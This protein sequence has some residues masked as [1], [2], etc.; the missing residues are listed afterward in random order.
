M[1]QQSTVLNF[2]YIKM[3]FFLI[4]SLL[5]CSALAQAGIVSYK[6]K[7]YKKPEKQHELIVEVNKE[8]D[9]MSFTLS[10]NKEF[11]YFKQD[12]SIPLNS[13]NHLMASATVGYIGPWFQYPIQ[14]E[15]I[16]ISK[17]QAEDYQIVHDKMNL[18]NWELTN[19]TKIIDGYECYKATRSQLNDRTLEFYTLVAWYTPDVSV[20]YGPIGE[21]YLPGLILQLIVADSYEYTV[22]EMTL[23]P[24]KVEIPKL[25]EAERVTPIEFALKLRKLRKVTED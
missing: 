24:E 7:R 20:P 18:A 25:K 19:E 21:G 10:Y 16:I 3:K 13:L 6:V 2:K 15:S 5:S 23:N 14:K 22:Q 8:L 12:K 9:L 1:A 11:S 17:V 4:L